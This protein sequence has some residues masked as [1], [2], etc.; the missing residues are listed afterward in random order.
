MEEGNRTHTPAELVSRVADEFEERYRALLEQSPNPVCVHQNGRLVYANAAALKLTGFRGIHELI[1]ASIFDFVPPESHPIIKDR[2]R[3]MHET[4]QPPPLIE[5]NCNWPNGSH[6]EVEIIAMPVPWHGETAIQIIL[7]DIT[8][9]KRA[10]RRLQESERLFHQLADSM[11][12][13]V[14]MAKPDGTIDYRNAKFFDQTGLTR[15]EAEA[16]LVIWPLVLHPHDVQRATE[17]WFRCVRDGVP[18]EM[19]YRYKKKG[20]GYR[21][22]LGRAL[23]IKDEH[24]DVIRWFGTCT[25]IHHIKTTELELEQ[26]RQD[27]A[28]SKKSLQKE[29]SSRSA[30]LNASIKSMED[31]CYSIAHNLRAPVRAMQGFS[32][33]LLEDY[34]HTLDPAGLDYI[35][36]IHH[37]AANM[38]SL[39]LDLLAYGRVDHQ[40]V[41]LQTIHL[42]D[43]IELILRHMMPDVKESEAK[44][45][46][47]NLNFQL[48]ADENMLRYIFLNLFSNAIKF[49]KPGE[50]PS[51]RIW[52]EEI[53]DKIKVVVQ[54][55]GIGI[56]PDHQQRIF[57]AFE[58]LNV[59]D[60]YPGTG[61]GL[62]IARKATA[63][64][65]GKMGVE[66]QVN[67]G[68][69]FWVELPKAGPEK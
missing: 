35:E 9:Q 33:A 1:G 69:C 19:E 32:T 11:P 18:F 13:I 54:D 30:K 42:H 21:W 2:I 5:L 45:E 68:S 34:H 15:D 38:D 25:D 62:A 36:R 28:N 6:S 64:L 44:F 59:V 14:W 20:D 46:L 61:I 65:G 41:T 58:R 43:A 26:A 3:L 48:T 49:S 12:Q 10:E 47:E 22:H 56:Q 57:Y 63:R 50:T 40:E 60:Q 66:S 29:V 51:V 4:G 24:G 8:E 17:K 27:L 37:S 23:P 16:A 7:R 31:F 67:K 52:A 53:D 39:I 55:N